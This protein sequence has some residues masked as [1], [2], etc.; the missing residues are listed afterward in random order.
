MDTPAL[1]TPLH[2]LVIDDNP[3]DVYTI[4]WV[5]SA[6]GVPYTLQVIENG[7]HARHFFDQLAQ[8]E[9][10][11]YPDIVLLDL[12]LPQH[13]GKALLQHIQ[14]LPQRAA[15]RVV[16]VT[17]STNPTDQA[18]TIAL[19]ADVCFVKSFSLTEFMQLGEIIKA[20]ACG[21]GEEA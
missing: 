9:A 1:R 19:G 15:M 4:R 7:E 17:G 12:N 11:R 20:W 3:V 13:H 18:E 14:T 2:I 6:N 16:V 8:Q 10:S 21:N 5:L